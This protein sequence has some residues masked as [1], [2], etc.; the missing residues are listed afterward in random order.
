MIQYVGLA[1]LS[2]VGLLT[3][4]LALFHGRATLYKAKLYFGS[5]IFLLQSRDTKFK[6]K[7]IDREIS[8]SDVIE[9][10]QKTLIFLRHGES[11]WNVTFNRSKNPIYFIPRLLHAG[12]YEV[13]LLLTGKRDSWFY[14]SPLCHEGIEQSK[15]LAN[16]LQTLPSVNQENLILHIINKTEGVNDLADSVIVSSNLRRSLS[17]AVITFGDRLKRTEESII[18]HHSMQEISRNPDT[19]SITPA[20]LQPIASWIEHSTSLNI[21]KTYQNQLQVTG[22]TGNKSVNSTGK[23]RL[24]EFNEWVFKSIEQEYI[25]VSGHSLWFRH[26][27]KEFLPAN[28]NHIAKTNKVS[29]NALISFKVTYRKLKSGEIHC[30]ID[31]SSITPVYKGFQNK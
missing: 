9:E 14:D 27:F 10:K 19:L 15:E 11:T 23:D 18:V 3:T 24:N 28:S 2:A 21:P 5:L 20:R 6:N 1:S 17:T 16:Y 8:P 31:P 25:I 22:N 13:Y 4:F 30:E 7:T 12:A 29:N 26:F